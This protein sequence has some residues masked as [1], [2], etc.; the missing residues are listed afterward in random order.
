ML[1]RN[2][3]SNTK[4][5]FQKTLQSFKSLFSEGYQKLPKTSPLNPFSSR[6]SADMN[7]QPSYKDL[8]KFY[9]DQ[10]ESSD[11]D[12]MKIMAK[13]GIIQKQSTMASST[14]QEK[15][16]Y[17]GS[18]LKFSQATAVKKNHVDRRRSEEYDH[19]HNHHEDDQ[20][21]SIPYQRRRQENS[22][23][24]GMMMREGGIRTCLVAQKLKEMETL[25]MGNVDHL[26]DIEEVLHYYSR[27]TCPAY[28]DIVD[29]FFLDIYE[30]FFGAATI[31]LTPASSIN[32]RLR[33]RRSVMRS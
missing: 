23:S 6:A 21:K 8:D 33:Q 15:E 26:L 25:D 16:V 29:K 24:K 1:L 28:L 18:F 20:I 19:H 27:L 31:A 4:K 7:V 10:W 12:H 13:K 9:T 5:F 32:S 17:G 14:Q 11:K 2:S 3:I 22:C 30:E